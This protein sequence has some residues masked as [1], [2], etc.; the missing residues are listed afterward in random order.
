MLGLLSAVFFSCSEDDDVTASK[1]DLFP[2]RTTSEIDK[3]HHEMFGD[4][5]T[6]IEYRYIKNYIPSDWYYITPVK[7]ELVLP[8]SN[9]VMDYWINPLIAGS[10]REFVAMTFPKLLVYIGSPAYQEDG[11]KVMGE[12]E[13]GTIIRF[14][15][16][17]AV[18]VNDDTW[19]TTQLHTAY[20][21]YAHIIHQRNGFPNE[22]RE[23]TPNSYVK[24]GWMTV[25][26]SLALKKGMVTP[27]ATSGVQEDF[28]ELFSTYVVHSQEELDHFFVDVVPE[29]G[30][31]LTQDQ[32]ETNQ[33]RAILRQKLSVQKKYMKNAGLDMDV[34]RASYQALLVDKK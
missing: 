29:E 1:E 20:H 32:I 2:K 11:S 9:I 6:R 25:S 27:Y 15:E 4:F 3:I 21:E 16:V 7:E 5:N 22:Y 28:V 14:T 24:S 23:I 12:A 34:I 31:S 13:G 30:K 17:N 19:R 18:D 10:S 8:M 33:G 26:E